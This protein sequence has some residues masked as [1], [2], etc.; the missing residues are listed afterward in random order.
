MIP[1][2]P[3]ET[4][5]A[6]LFAITAEHIEKIIHHQ[7][8]SSSLTSSSSTIQ[9]SPVSLQTIISVHAGHILI[10]CPLHPLVVAIVTKPHTTTSSTPEEEEEEANSSYSSSSSTTTTVDQ[11]LDIL[12]S[13]LKVLEPLRTTAAE[14]MNG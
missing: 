14:Y 11:I 1:Y 10:Q 6:T 13:F 8:T 2:E 3:L 4:I 7:F 5:Y 9:S 12:P